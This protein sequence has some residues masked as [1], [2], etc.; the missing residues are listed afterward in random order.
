MK[1][2]VGCDHIVTNDKIAVVDYLKTQGYEVI[3]C[4]TYDNVRTHYPIFGKK[5]GEAVAS[6]E[7]DLGVCICGTG[8]GINNAVNKVPGIRSALVRDMT[9]AIYAKE[10]LNANVIGFGGKITGGLLMTDI[11]EAFI[12]TEYKPTEENK[13][14]IEKIAKVESLNQRQADPHFFDEFLEKW[15]RG[16][17]HD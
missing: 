4:G 14:L 16:E 7:A 13:A 3:D 9:S 10:E 8:V 15:D 1:I 17:Y 6:G 2:A 11:I 5:V 12:H